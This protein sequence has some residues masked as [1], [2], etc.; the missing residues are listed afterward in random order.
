M[1]VRDCTREGLGP[2]VL[3]HRRWNGLRQREACGA[4]VAFDLLAW[5]RFVRLE[6]APQLDDLGPIARARREDDGPSGTFD[7]ELDDHVARGMRAA[8]RGED[9]GQLP[10]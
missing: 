5:T 4:Q 2:E 10:R 3:H 7:I 8:N 1:R 6:L 9:R